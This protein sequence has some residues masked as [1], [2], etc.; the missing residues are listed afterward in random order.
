MPYAVAQLLRVLDMKNYFSRRKMQTADLRL[1]RV[2]L[3]WP[4]E[5]GCIQPE[6][7]VALLAKRKDVR[8]L[9]PAGLEMTFGKSSDFAV[10]M[11]G[12][13]EMLESVCEHG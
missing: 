5:Q 4:E 3:V 11:G 12:L 10:N 2:R 1:E 7:L 8:L 6:R 13:R 9:P